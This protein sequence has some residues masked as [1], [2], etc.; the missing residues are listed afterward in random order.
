MFEISAATAGATGAGVLPTL[1][2]VAPVLSALAVV[3]LFL[4]FRRFVAND[5]VAILGATLGALFMPRIFSVAHPA[6]LAL[7]D[8][9]V[10]AMV[11]MF[12]ESRREV[13]WYLPLGVTAGALI[14]THHLSMLLLP[15]RAPS[16]SSS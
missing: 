8:F 13:R 7:G 1:Q 3:P 12:L 2:V 10:I 5:T 11:W 14:V 6:P 9:F 15:R 4:A 16:A